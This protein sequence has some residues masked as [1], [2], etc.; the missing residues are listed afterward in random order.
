MASSSFLLATCN[1][2]RRNKL[3][4]PIKIYFVF[5]IFIT[6]KRDLKVIVVQRKRWPLYMQK[7]KDRSNRGMVAQAYKKNE[8][9]ERSC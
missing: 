9:G 8:R 2:V 6:A 7:K 4:L 1:T 3:R 5:F